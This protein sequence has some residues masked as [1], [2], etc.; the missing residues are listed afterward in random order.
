MTPLQ[1]AA[2]VANLDAVRLLL[3]Y[4][5]QVNAP[6]GD[7][8]GRTALQ[9]AVCGKYPEDTSAMVELLLSLGADVNA[10]PARKGG[11]TALQGAAISGDI[12]IVKKLLDLGADVNAAPAAKDGRTAI[13]GAAE[14]GR[15]DM[16]RFLISVGAVGD[17]EKGFSRAIEL[18]EN[19]NHFT[20]AD[21]LR[22]QQGFSA[23]FGMGDD[24]FGGD[25]FSQVPMPGFVFSEENLEN[26]TFQ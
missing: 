1:V 19:E 3:K 5:A 21:F 25:L 8:F 7:E 12:C 4:G 17:V 2:G 9:M 24:V 23:G 16:V 26:F 20:I 6:P 22:D 18:A 14:H 13:E 10:P 15:L 11:I